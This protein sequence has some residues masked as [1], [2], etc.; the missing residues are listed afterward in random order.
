MPPTGKP[1]KL[2]TLNCHEAWIHQLGYLK[3]HLDIVD[4]LPNRQPASWDT[5]ARP[6]PEKGRLITLSEALAKGTSHDYDCLIAHNLSDLMDLKTLPGPR[7][8]VL[9]TT[10]DGRI[11]GSAPG[12]RSPEQIREV[13]KQYLAMIGGHV[14]AVS[15]LKGQSWGA[16][17]DVVPFG[18]DVNQ[19]PP[20]RGEIAAGIRIANQ[21]TAKGAVL[22]W[23][24]HEA[25][26]GSLPVRLVGHNP[27]LAGVT[28]SKSWDDLKNLLASHRFFIHTAHPDLEDGYN[29]ATLEAMAAGLPVL[30]N[31]HPSSPI[32][33]GVS[34]FLS[35]DPLELKARA[36]ELL[37]D[38]ERAR[39]MGEAAKE[40]V[41]TKLSTQRFARSFRKSITTAQ[42]KYRRFRF[43]K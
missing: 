20:W 29:M 8:L 30:G 43:K 27:D 16:L 12:G 19:Y 18:A 1:L 40:A 33:S 39:N 10:L 9:H 32:K 42:K 25:A 41:R 38:P 5:F 34:G 15:R 37:Q 14:V 7:I 21:I 36:E 11:R 24:F 6:V 17:G 23:D 3:G 31:N 35:D 2:L 28:P 4:G 26:F 22:M 13:M